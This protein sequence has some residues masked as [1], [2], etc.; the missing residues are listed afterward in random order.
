M[1]T[2]TGCKKRPFDY[3]NEFVGDWQ[4]EREVPQPA[5]DTAFTWVTKVTQGE[6]YYKGKG[7]DIFIRYDEDLFITLT[8]EENGIFA[9][10]AYDGG[11]FGDEMTLIA[12]YGGPNLTGTRQ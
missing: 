2:W 8:I 5:G 6:I 10:K 3:R 7:K 12:W 1:S 11:I 4:F 9:E